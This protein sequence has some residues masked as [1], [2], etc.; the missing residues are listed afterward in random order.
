MMVV[1]T[2]EDRG[3]W[4][5]S[6][7]LI[8]RSGVAQNNWEGFATNA[9]VIVLFA[10]V[11]PILC[12]SLF[13]S[14]YRYNSFHV[15]IHKNITKITVENVSTSHHR[16]RKVGMQSV[17]LGICPIAIYERDISTDRIK[18]I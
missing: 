16:S 6:S 17:R 1:E 2:K 10:R 18:S 15:K 14:C 12:N 9:Y 13:H 5:P 8:F 4:S 3:P 11:G 7:K